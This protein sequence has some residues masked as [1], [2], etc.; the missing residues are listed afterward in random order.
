MWAHFRTSLAHYR[1]VGS[2]FQSLPAFARQMTLPLT[3]PGENR[4]VLEVGPGAGPMTRFIVQYLRSGDHL[5]IVEINPHFVDIL[6]R[7]ILEPARSTNESI[8][9]DVHCA[10]IQTAPLEGPYDFI[11]SS[12]PLNNF[13]PA[14]VRV[15]L[16]RYQQLLGPAGELHFFEYAV[17]RRL[18]C[19]FGTGARRRQL[20]EISAVFEEFDRL[21][22]SS[23]RIHLMNV[24][25]A[26][27]R[28]LVRRNGSTRPLGS[29]GTGSHSKS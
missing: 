6:E 23:R 12:L 26:I 24:P 28:S 20:R 10:P 14:D 22:D 25:P 7:E 29:N 21:P 8:T 1:D 18:G 2:P 16:D 13:D 17:I 4:R 5:D 3:K 11:F 15:I 27:K 9:I 19:L